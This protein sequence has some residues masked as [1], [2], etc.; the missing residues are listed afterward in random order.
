MLEQAQRREARD[1]AQNRRRMLFA[2]AL[3]LAA[4][5]V[6][7]VRDHTYWFSGDETSATEDKTYA[8]PSAPP[9]A[10]TL[11]AQATPSVSTPVVRTRS[12]K[13]VAAAVPV[14][15]IDRAAVRPLQIEVVVDGRHHALQP[16]GNSVKLDLQSSP[17]TNAVQRTSLTLDKAL[18]PSPYPL[19]AGKTNIQGA[20]LLQALIDVNGIIRDL[21]VISG[22]DILSS[23]ARV[24]AMQWRFR[25]YL[26]NGKAVETQARI[27]VNFNIKVSDDKARDQDAAHK[28]NP[29]QPNSQLANP[30]N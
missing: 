11:V 20:V 29:L 3:L 2:L 18:P 14:V 1:A 9:P 19:L 10:P 26:Q 23:A 5:T 4:I 16:D 21:H 6:I 28:H 24:A 25:P 12:I 30:G 8:A 13:A 15:A 7:L 27:T 17:A 22:P